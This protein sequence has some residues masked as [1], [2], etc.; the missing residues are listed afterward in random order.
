M[1]EDD[2]E[3]VPQDGKDEIYDTISEEIREL[4]EELDEKLK[5]YEDQL[6]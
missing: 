4:E 1:Y 2:D 3:L 5:E 6:R